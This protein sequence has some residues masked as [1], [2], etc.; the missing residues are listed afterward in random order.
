MKGRPP[1]AR[2]AAVPAGP[3]KAER[4]GAREFPALGGGGLGTS[5]LHGQPAHEADPPAKR[6]I[7]GL[8]H[9]SHH[10]PE[11]SRAAGGGWAWTGCIWLQKAPGWRAAGRST[12]PGGGGLRGRPLRVPA[13]LCLT[14]ACPQRVPRLAGRVWEEG[15]LGRRGLAPSLPQ[16][17]DGAGGACVAGDASPGPPR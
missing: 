9:W 16:M 17:V 6:S 14:Q 10:V 5:V 13:S 12:F 3:R 4:R 7:L 8:S 1:R 2:D 11:G 15:Q